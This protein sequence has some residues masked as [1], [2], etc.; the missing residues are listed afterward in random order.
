MLEK[1]KASA[2]DVVLA[3]FAAFAA[4]AATYLVAVNSGAEITLPGLKI[5]AITA[6]YAALRAAAGALAAKLA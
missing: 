1:L 3:A 4:S 2:R 5:A 6:G